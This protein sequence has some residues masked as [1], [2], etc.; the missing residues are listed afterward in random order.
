MP[1]LYQLYSI[2]NAILAVVLF[3]LEASRSWQVGKPA[4]SDASR[5]AHLA[6]HLQI[7]A[8]ILPASVVDA[9]A[10]GT[11]RPRIAAVCTTVRLVSPRCCRPTALPTLPASLG[12]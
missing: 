11:Y 9:A 5:L 1:V 6:Q 8:P 2:S 4:M 7:T 12:C 10:A 3:F